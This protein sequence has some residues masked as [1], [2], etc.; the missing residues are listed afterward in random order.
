MSE[1]LNNYMIVALFMNQMISRLNHEIDN[2]TSPE[3]RGILINRRNRTEKLKRKYEE[4]AYEL[5]I[6]EGIT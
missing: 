4:K 2:S 1:L 3:T 6:K 5:C